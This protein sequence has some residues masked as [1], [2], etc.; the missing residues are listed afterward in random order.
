MSVPRTILIKRR[1]TGNT[2]APNNLKNG[3]LAYN[4]V[5]DNLYYGSGSDE[6]GNAVNIISIAG[7]HTNIL[8]DATIINSNNT[9]QPTNSYLIIKVNG[10]EKL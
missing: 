9:P 3:E 1:K 4:E 10:V 8:K 6:N 7:N 2:G 5:D